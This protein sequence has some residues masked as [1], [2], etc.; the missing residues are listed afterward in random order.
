MTKQDYYTIPELDKLSLDKNGKCVVNSFSIGRQD[1]GNISFLT[2]VDVAGMNFDETG[3]Y[4]NINLFNLL[5]LTRR[6]VRFLSVD[7]TLFWKFAHT[8]I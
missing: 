7:F 8:Y 6:I 2:P 4:F 3:N 1:F 5:S